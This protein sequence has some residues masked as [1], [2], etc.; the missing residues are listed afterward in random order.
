MDNPFNISDI[1][2]FILI[3]AT[4]FVTSNIERLVKKTDPQ[5][6]YL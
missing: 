1:Q 5:L 4:N 3:E 6:M 2:C